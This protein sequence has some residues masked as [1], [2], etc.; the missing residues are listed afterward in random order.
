LVLALCAQLESRW[1]YA[2][3]IY[4]DAN[5]SVCKHLLPREDAEA[6]MV[7]WIPWAIAEIQAAC[8]QLAAQFALLTVEQVNTVVVAPEY[9]GSDD[10]GL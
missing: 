7:T 3:K 6:K 10:E 1:K 5:P 9:E 4:R 2:A 8:V